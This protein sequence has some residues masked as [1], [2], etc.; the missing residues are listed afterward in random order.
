VGHRRNKREIREEIKRFLEVIENENTTYQKLW[1]TKRAVLT[2]THI[3]M[4]A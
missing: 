2:G 1:N 4:S 3:A